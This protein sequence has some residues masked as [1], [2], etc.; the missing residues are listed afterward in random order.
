M[1]K[2]AV[3]YFNDSPFDL[4]DGGAGA[5]VSALLRLVEK[6]QSE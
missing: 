6:V 5:F 2:Q 4:L 1:D 3:S